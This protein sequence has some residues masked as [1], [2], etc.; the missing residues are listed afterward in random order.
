MKAAMVTDAITIV[1]MIAI[2]ALML[3]KVPGMVDD[4]KTTL[5]QESVR[6]Q[7]IEIANMITLVTAS[8][9]DIKIIHKLPSGASFTITV[10]DGNVTV[11]SGAFKAIAKT[12]SGLTFG[13]DT[14]RTLSITKN[15]IREVE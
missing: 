5:S 11:Q 9:Y 12:S 7:A 4:M 13:P 2:S 3:V 6:S 14:V 1:G 10:N 15:E 8:P